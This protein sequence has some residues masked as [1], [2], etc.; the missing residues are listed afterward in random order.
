MLNTMKTILITGAA[1]RIGAFLAE[2][3]HE[4]GFNIIIHYHQSEQEAQTLCKQL[5]QK[6]ADSAFLI[7]ADLNDNQSASYIIKQVYALTGRLDVLIHNASIFNTL[8][9]N[10][11]R[12]FQIHVKTPYQLSQLALPLLKQYQ[13]SIIN[14]TDIFAEKPKKNY[15]AYLQSKAALHMQTLSLAL[16]FAPLVRV[17]EIAPGKNLAPIHYNPADEQQI[18]ESIPLK[19]RGTPLDIAKAAGFLI[20]ASYV[21]G[22]VIR[23]DGGKFIHYSN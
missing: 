13:G 14:I 10:W 6:R 21:T 3:F 17:N 15:S 16:E 22:Q 20:D 5:L 19:R 8:D 12:F 1:K 18:L 7:C 11:D 9:E 4:Q 2:Y 23:V